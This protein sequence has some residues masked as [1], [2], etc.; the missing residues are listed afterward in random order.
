M[1]VL[2]A[3][4]IRECRIL[5]SGSNLFKTVQI[6]PTRFGQIYQESMRLVGVVSAANFTRGVPNGTALC[7]LLSAYIP[8][9]LSDPEAKQQLSSVA[10]PARRAAPRKLCLLRRT[11]NVDLLL[12]FV[13]GVVLTIAFSMV[14]GWG[15]AQ[16]VKP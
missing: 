15:I 2:L 16:I 6:V 8:M 7:A 10:Y 5:S 12:G 14:L 4:Y 3:R 9:S 1:R 11:Y 13:L